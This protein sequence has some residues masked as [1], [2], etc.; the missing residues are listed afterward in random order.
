MRGIRTSISTTSGCSAAARSTA[1][2]PSAASPTT[3]MSG[4]ADSNAL[5]PARTR[6]WSSASRTR[7]TPAP[8]R[9]GATPRR[10]SRRPARAGVERPAQRRRPLAHPA[11]ARSGAAAP[12]V[13][14]PVVGDDDRHGVHVHPHD[15]RRARRAGVPEHVRQG[16]LHDP[17]ARGA[18][19]G[20]HGDRGRVDRH[21]DPRGP[22]LGR[23]VVEVVEPG[24][25]TD[26]RG[27]LRVAQ[28]PERGPQVVERVPARALDVQQRLARLLGV[29]VEQ[30]RRDPG[31][32]VDRDHRVRDHV[33]HLAGDPQPLL[34]ERAGPR[35]RPV[36]A[37]RLCH[38]R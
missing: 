28:H 30:V 7:V 3:S 21:L 10:A 29:L 36:I 8:P 19:R 13:A 12:A 14:G 32:H 9:A 15:D 22:Q 2:A 38:I 23:D 17:V 25:G 1:S 24:G 31:L 34:V 11:H 18:H 26:R 33:V 16:L 5:N 20:G 27:L 37:S 6:P 4:C 35:S